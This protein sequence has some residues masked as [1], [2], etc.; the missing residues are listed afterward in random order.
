MNRQKL[1]AA[2]WK[3]NLN[4]HQAS[5]LLNRLD[6][7]VQ[8]HRDVEVVLAPNYLCLQPLSLEIDRR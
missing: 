5:T 8:L 6:K 2:N 3:M 7:H 4:I 1:V